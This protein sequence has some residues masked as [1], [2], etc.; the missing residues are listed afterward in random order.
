ML[1][2][3]VMGQERDAESPIAAPAL[4]A[5]QIQAGA[6]FA[7]ASPLIAASPLRHSLAETALAND[8]SAFDLLN[9]DP[10]SAGQ[11]RSTSP[12]NLEISLPRTTAHDLDLQ[13]VA[14]RPT[15]DD[16]VL[17]SINKKGEIPEQYS[18][19]L[20]YWGVI[21]DQ[22]GSWVALTVFENEIMAVMHHPTEGTITLGLNPK[23]PEGEHVLFS[24]SA[25]LNQLPFNCGTMGT[26]MTPGE[27]RDLHN[28]ATNGSSSRVSKCVK[29]YFE[30]EYDMYLEKGSVTNTANYVTGLFNVVSLLYALE[31]IP[32]QI[33][34]IAV[35]PAR[36][37]LR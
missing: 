1:Q 23:G 12:A 7:S 19:V 6:E 33:S 3:P 31:S 25:E 36:P 34:Q 5:A 10:I 9:L 14:V 32:V 21:K 2:L 22:P 4:V 30:C 28:Q 11:L 37:F 8:L 26:D 29:V 15:T 13:L 27:I 20:H 24:S 35:G 17:T 16:F 18:P